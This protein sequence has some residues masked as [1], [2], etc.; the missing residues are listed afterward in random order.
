MVEVFLQPVVYL[1]N[2]QDIQGQ[3]VFVNG[4]LAAALARLEGSTY[5]PSQQGLWNLEAGFGCCDPVLRIE[6]FKSLDEA[7]AWVAGQVQARLS[8]KDRR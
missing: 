8:H 5:L 2:D 3:L 4:R 7:Q 6:P 1:I